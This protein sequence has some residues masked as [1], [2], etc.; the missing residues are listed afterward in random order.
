MKDNAT[1]IEPTYKTYLLSNEWHSTIIGFFIGILMIAIYIWMAS[2]FINLLSGLYHAYPDNWTH[3]AEGM[4]KDTVIILASLELIRVFQSY[5]LIGRVKVTFILD[6]A[7]VVLIGELISLW[8]AEY[9]TNEV[10]LSIFVIAS[11][12]AL[13]IITMKFSPDCNEAQ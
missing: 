10:L 5:L 8:Y 13:R 1:V 6:V 12:I 4:I 9:D 3:G 7:L 11:L 2:G